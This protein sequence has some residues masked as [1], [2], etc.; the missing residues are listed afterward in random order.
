MTRKYESTCRS[1]HSA[2][3][4]FSLVTFY[5]AAFPINYRGHWNQHSLQACAAMVAPRAL[6]CGTSAAPWLLTQGD[7]PGCG[8]HMIKKRKIALCNFGFWEKRKKN[9]SCW[10][11]FGDQRERTGRILL[12]TWLEREHP[13]QPDFRDSAG[14]PIPIYY[15]LLINSVAIFYLL[16]LSYCRG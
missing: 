7:F 3:C 16:I 15:V 12:N 13:S 1:W 6:G 11:V 2:Y 14:W 4:L 5:L 10:K 9:R 8:K